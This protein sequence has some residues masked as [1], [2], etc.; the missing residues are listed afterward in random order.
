MLEEAR[1]ATLLAR[2]AGGTSPTVRKGA[3]HDRFRGIDP[4]TP[5][6][7]AE[8][9]LFAATL[10]GARALGRDDQIGA[11]ADG[12]Q[13]DITVFRLTGA[14]QQPVRDPADALVFA[15]SGRDVLLTMVAG[16]EVYRNGHIEGVDENEFRERLEQ[17]R[18][19]IDSTSTLHR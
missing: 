16:K 9:A 5:P 6:V 8:Q 19:K 1:F 15:S 13:A 14:H 7:S 4:S 11:L 17:V 10:G 12:R 3:N 2:M 18:T